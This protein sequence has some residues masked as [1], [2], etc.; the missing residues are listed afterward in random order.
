VKRSL[1]IPESNGGIR[2]TGLLKGSLRCLLHY[3]VEP[4]IH[5]PNA[6]QVCTNRL[7]R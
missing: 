1:K 7:S 5:L 2:F 6:F 4:R 3:R